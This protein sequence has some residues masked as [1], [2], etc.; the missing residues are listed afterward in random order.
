MN[1]ANLYIQAIEREIELKLSGYQ[2]AFV[3][4]EQ[5]N[6]SIGEGDRVYRLLPSE[7]TRARFEDIVC[8]LRKNFKNGTGC[9]QVPESEVPRTRLLNENFRVME[10]FEEKNG[11]KGK[12]DEVWVTLSGKIS[13]GHLLCVAPSIAKEIAEI[14]AMEIALGKT[15]KLSNEVADDQLRRLEENVGIWECGEALSQMLSGNVEL[16]NFER[17]PLQ[18]DDY[19]VLKDNSRAGNAEQ[20]DF[21]CTAL[22][23]PDFAV[24]EGPPGSGKT[25]VIVELL[26]QLLRRGKR[27]L[28][29]ASTNVAVDNILEKLFEVYPDLKNFS[30]KRYGDSDNGKISIVGK[31]FLAKDFAKTESQKWKERLGKVSVRTPEQ[32]MLLES[33]A[34]QNNEILYS[35]LMENAP[36]VAGTTFGAALPEMRK[37]SGEGEKPFFDYLVLDEASKTT[38][39]EFLVPAILCKHWIVVGDIKQ[40]PPYVDDADFAH[41]LRACYP[42]ESDM[43]QEF[44]VASDALLASKGKGN[45]Q[46]CILVEKESGYDSY[47]YKKYAEKFGILCV[48]ADSGNVK[49]LPY[50]DIVLGSADSFEK[51]QG[52]LPPR[53]TTV[54]LARDAQSGRILHE[55][56]M[57]KWVSVARYNR[58]KV[59]KRFGENEPR[60]WHDEVSWRVVRLFEQRDNV[61]NTAGDFRT[62]LK[63]QIR[64]LIPASSFEETERKIRLLEQIYLPSCMELFL[65]GYGEFRDLALFRGIPSE[66]L[67]ARRVTLS[68]QHRSHPDIARIASHE[69]YDD[70]A[71]LSPHMEGKREWDYPRYGKEHNIWLDVRGCFDSRSVNKN[72]LK[73]IERELHEFRKFAA[74][75]KK[76]RGKWSV[77]AL[78]FYKE[79]AAELERI[80]KKVF[81]GATN[82]VEFKAGS[83]DSFQGHEADAVF[84]SYANTYPTNFLEAPNRLNV[85]ITRARFLMAHVGNFRQMEKS[86]GALGRIVQK[87][88]RKTFQKQ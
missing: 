57:Q 27:V 2:T 33:C 40:L 31:K 47:L 15:F 70:K 56:E 67:N 42:E 37:F 4:V 43:R 17:V 69:F 50:A 84:L 9:Y 35:L 1:Q 10:K 8:A 81:N 79:Q 83:V 11:K 13:P 21:V 73:C 12:N 23:T 55:Q 64:A 58:E 41:N 24:L 66:F 72:E 51:V 44:V 78:S 48:D 38:F 25:T 39:Q 22:S 32:Q 18:E 68:F 63:K 5:V 60:E 85:A 3:K 16:P 80:C 26:L 74:K 71:M 34:P 87:I 20:R 65:R 62:D 86:Q 82:F 6:F 52:C 28:L 77:A 49:D 45:R 46:T 76:R 7:R 75:H 14:F 59:F 53:I 36:I 29:V 61:F 30:A 88:T 54:R 19:F